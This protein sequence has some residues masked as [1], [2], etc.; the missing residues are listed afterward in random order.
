MGCV[1]TAKSS[2]AWPHQVAQ[3]P[4][5]PVFAASRHCLAC[6]A[7]SACVTCLPSSPLPRTQ[8]TT[9]SP[10]CPG[11]VIRQGPGVFSGVARSRSISGLSPGFTLPSSGEHL[12]TRGPES[13]SGPVKSEPWGESRRVTSPLCTARA[14]QSRDCSG[15]PDPPPGA[16]GTMTN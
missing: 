12:R 7:P 4:W 14:C 2:S 1:R 5:E 6:F 9:C 16:L 11:P 15:H 8:S 3:A 10:R 13:H